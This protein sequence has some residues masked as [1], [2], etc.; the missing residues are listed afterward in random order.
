MMATMEQRAVQ[1]SQWEA[2][3]SQ[4]GRAG[5]KARSAAGTPGRLPPQAQSPAATPPRLLRKVFL[6][7]CASSSSTP[8]SN[9]R[10]SAKAGCS[11]AART[12]YGQAGRSVVVGTLAG[13]SSR[14]SEWQSERCLERAARSMRPP[15][16]L[17]APAAA[18][19]ARPPAPR[20]GAAARP[21]PPAAAAW[22]R[23]GRRWRPRCARG[24]GSALRTSCGFRREGGRGA[25][26]ATLQLEA[27]RAPAAH[28]AALQRASPQCLHLPPPPQQAL[29]CP[30]L[31]AGGPGRRPR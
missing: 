23:C 10:S 18:R 31:W 26:Q 7:G 27:A 30:G 13:G 2:W 25:G 28:P 14:L 3:A 21:A 5:G 11:Q 12:A 15:L 4:S 6:A 22:P 8:S 19:T 17:T 20:P 1:G 29:A 16:R 9:A 24:A